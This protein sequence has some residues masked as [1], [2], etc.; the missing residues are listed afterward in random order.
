MDVRG[1]FV[2]TFG[3]DQEMNVYK[4]IRQKDKEGVVHLNIALLK[5]HK[6]TVLSEEQ[7]GEKKMGFKTGFISG[8]NKNAILVPGMSFL[9]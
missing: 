7:I 6:I 3:G 1:D 5:S 9:Q 4:V 2:C 8:K